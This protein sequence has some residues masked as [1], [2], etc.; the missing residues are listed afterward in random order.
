MSHIEDKHLLQKLKK[1]KP[2]KFFKKFLSLAGEIKPVNN[3]SS[4]YLQ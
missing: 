2:I 1:K 3:L 4:L